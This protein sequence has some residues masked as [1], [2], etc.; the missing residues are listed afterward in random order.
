MN[1]ILQ[2]RIEEAAYQYIQS[3]AVE[4]ENMQLAF[5]D[6]INGAKWGLQNQWISVDEELP[7]QENERQFFSKDILFRE[8][9]SVYFGWYDF[10][11]KYF[12]NPIGC[13]FTK[14]TH[15]MPIPPLE[16]GEE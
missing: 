13:T 3:N 5:G 14:V 7:K 10:E 12:R 15:W 4:P 9:S 11:E 16:G 8:N 1:E 2:K 6:F